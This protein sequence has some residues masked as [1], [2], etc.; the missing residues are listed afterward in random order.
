MRKHPIPIMNT[1]YVKNLFGYGYL[2]NTIQ[3][4]SNA[5]YLAARFNKGIVYPNHPLLYDTNISVRPI[6]G[7]DDT[8]LVFNDLFF[9][10]G[11]GKQYDFNVAHLN[12]D[13]KRIC[14]KIIHPLLKLDKEV[15]L[16]DD[17]LVIHIRTGDIFTPN[18]PYGIM[19]PNPMFYYDYLCKKYAKI[20]VVCQ[21]RAN[22]VINKLEEYSNATIFESSNIMESFGLLLNAKNLATSGVST[23]GYAAALCSKKIKKLH[24]TNITA[25]GQLNYEMLLGKI[26]VELA[27]IDLP[28]YIPEN[29]WSARPEQI[30]KILSYTQ[31]NLDVYKFIKM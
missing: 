31:P 8:D 19:T 5:F 14:E 3:A 12:Y 26:D 7:Q 21:D 1:I 18:N 15:D 10:E 6:P 9:F 20:I 17:T 28:N 23:F 30:E 16:D 25:F 29:S 27:E 4:L 13:R 2:G 24:A 22:P 11:E